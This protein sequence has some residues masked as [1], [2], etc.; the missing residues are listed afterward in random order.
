MGRGAV[1]ARI[2]SGAF[3]VGE[4]TRVAQQADDEPV[5]DTSHSR[6][7]F[8]QPGNRAD[9]AG[10]EHE[11]IPVLARAAGK[12]SRE[13]AGDCDTA[14]IVIRQRGVANVREDDDLLGYAT[15]QKALRVGEAP[16]LQIG[17]DAHL[18][19]AFRKLEQVA[20]AQAESPVPAVV[21]GPVG[22]PVGRVGEAVQVRPQRGQ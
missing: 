22:D 10:R 20:M 5:G 4:R 17:V 1:D 14:G 7:V 21:A 8:R 13:L 15:R 2:P 18:V 19:V 6:L 9:R 3:L 11:A 16:G 12:R